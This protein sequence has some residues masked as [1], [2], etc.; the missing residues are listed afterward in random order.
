MLL[1][2]PIAQF[3]WPQLHILFELLERAA[4]LD[5]S[6]TNWRDAELSEAIIPNLRVSSAA[7]FRFSQASQTDP[8]SEIRRTS[9]RL[10]WSARI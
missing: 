8:E 6:F 10:M 2:S 5:C 9:A 1:S 4:T 7:T 3:V